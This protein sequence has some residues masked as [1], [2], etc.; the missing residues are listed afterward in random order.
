MQS[1]C[2]FLSESEQERVHEESLK[3]LQEVGALFHSDRALKIL[4]KNGANVD[5]E[6]KIAKI[7]ME[8]VD[9]TLK[10]APGNVL[11]RFWSRPRKTH[12]RTMSSASWKTS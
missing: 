1:T 12:C 3:I 9:Q 4:E 7:P 5:K 8:M 6:S 11:K 10:T 2:Q